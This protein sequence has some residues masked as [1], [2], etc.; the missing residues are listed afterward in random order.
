[1]I[2]QILSA[3]AIGFVAFTSISDANCKQRFETCNGSCV[4]PSNWTTRVCQIECELETL[5]MEENPALTH[6]E[7]ICIENC[8]TDL[9]AV[10]ECQEE[11][12]KARITCED[13]CSAART[14]ASMINKTEA[15]NAFYNCTGEP[16]PLPATN[17]TTHLPSANFSTPLPATNFSMF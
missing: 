6:N 9:E 16:K 1:M 17:F 11:C 10:T 7:T 3:A 5:E 12:L 14:I 8:Q 4:I 13:G 2:Y 15:D